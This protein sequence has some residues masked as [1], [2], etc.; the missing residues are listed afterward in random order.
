VAVEY[1]CNSGRPAVTCGVDATART[2]AMGTYGCEVTGSGSTVHVS[3]NLNCTGF[4]GGND[5]GTLFVLVRP[6]GS[7][8]Y[9]EGHQLR[10]DVR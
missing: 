7:V 4:I 10:D 3:A 2:D 1:Q 9:C 5:S 6:Q 8:L